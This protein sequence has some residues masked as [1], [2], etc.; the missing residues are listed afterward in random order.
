MRV[1]L[2][3]KNP[4]TMSFYIPAIQSIYYISQSSSKFLHWSHGIQSTSSTNIIGSN[5]ESGDVEV[6]IV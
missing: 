2:I 1:V 6:F 5:H 4:D 3:Q